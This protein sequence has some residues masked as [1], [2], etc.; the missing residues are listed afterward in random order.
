MKKDLFSL[1][2]AKKLAD[3]AF[4]DLIEFGVHV[5]VLEE[6]DLEALRATALEKNVALMTEEHVSSMRTVGAV[7]A[8]KALPMDALKV[9][10]LYAAEKAIRRLSGTDYVSN[11]SN[12][13]IYLVR[14]KGM[15]LFNMEFATVETTTESDLYRT[16]QNAF[17]VQ[18]SFLTVMPYP[19][20]HAFLREHVSKE[21]HVLF[22]G[23]HWKYHFHAKCA[24][25]FLRTRE[26]LEKQ[27]AKAVSEK[28]AHSWDY[29]TYK[30]YP[31]MRMDFLKT[32]FLE[33]YPESF[34]RITSERLIIPIPKGDEA[35]SR[36]VVAALRNALIALKN[37]VF[38][39]LNKDFPN[40]STVLGTGES[41]KPIECI[42]ALK[43]NGTYEIEV[44]LSCF[45]AIA[46]HLL[47]A[48]SE[49][50]SV[51]ST[52]SLYDIDFPA[53]PLQQNLAAKILE[54]TAG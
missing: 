45:R 31:M 49:G 33:P 53:S 23:K 18:A 3:D 38:S 20:V 6:E 43:E 29:L 28:A 1:E 37:N 2:H 50:V 48:E 54:S 46:E 8:L 47:S 11:L 35:D 14:K 7:P 42:L 51:Y 36:R 21:K 12:H 16:T 17:G 32:C 22:S 41:G 40:G 39:M 52:P 13:R 5:F 24:E 44:G 27:C 4:Q 25:K 30:D 9:L 26:R 19:E 34:F 15:P 10:S